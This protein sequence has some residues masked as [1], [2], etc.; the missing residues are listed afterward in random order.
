MRIRAKAFLFS[1]LAALIFSSCNNFFH[2]LIPPSDNEIKSFR[3]MDRNGNDV[4]ESSEIDGTNINIKVRPDADISSLLPLIEKPEKSSVFPIT[5][6][7]IHTAAPSAN[8]INVARNIQESRQAGNLSDWALDFVQKTPDFNVP[9]L[10]QPISFIASVPIAVIA[11]T[12]NTKIYQVN[13]EHGEWTGDDGIEGNCEKQILSFT[14]EGQEGESEITTNEVHFS[15]PGGTDVR[16]ILPSVVVSSGASVLPFTQD[17]ILDLV[18]TSDF[19][20]LLSGYSATNRNGSNTPEKF[21]ASWIRKNN[22]TFPTELT[23]EID[24]SS[25]VD[26]IVRG[27][28]GSV[29]IYKVSC[30]VNSDTPGLTSL[31]FAK[32]TNENLVRDSQTVFNAGTTSSTMDIIYPAEY[33]SDSAGKEDAFHLVPSFVME[34]DKA[35]YSMDGSTWTLLKDSETAIPFTGSKKDCRIKISRG[36]KSTE[37]E[38]NLNYVEDPDTIR[39]VTDFRFPKNKNSGIRATAMASIVDDGNMGTI[40]VTVLYTGTRPTELTPTFVTPGSLYKD[41]DTQTSGV[42]SNC[43]DTPFQYLCISR[44]GM[45]S[46]T[47]TVKVNFVEVQPAVAAMRT[48]TFPQILNPALSSDAVGIINDS[49]ET[50]VVNAVYFNEKPETLVAE[51]SA[52]GNV[53]A[54]GIPQSSGSSKLDFRYARSYTVTASDDPET[55][56]TY[57]VQVVY[58]MDASR[59]CSLDSLCFM[60]EDNPQLSKDVTVDISQTNMTGTALLPV[61]SDKKNTPLIARFEAQGV[62]SINGERQTSGVNAVSFADDVVYTVTSA[63]GSVT[64]EY[65]ISLTETGAIVYVNKNA[66]GLNN[67]TSWED[68]YTTLKAASD[69]VSTN[70]PD[71]T[72]VEVWIADREYDDYFNYTARDSKILTVRGGFDGTEAAESERGAEKISTNA[73]VIVQNKAHLKDLHL[74]NLGSV[75]VIDS[76]IHGE[77]TATKCSGQK[78][79]GCGIYNSS[80]NTVSLTDCELY[81]NKVQ[82]E[83]DFNAEN[84]KGE[85]YDVS[86]KQLNMSNCTCGLYNAKANTAL[87]SDSDLNSGT[88]TEN[89]RNSLTLPTNSNNSVIDNCKIG[90]LD[91]DKSGGYPDPGLCIRDCVIGDIAL[92]NA[93]YVSFYRCKVGTL[94]DT[95]YGIRCKTGK[96]YYTH[97]KSIRNSEI[98]IPDLFYTGA[99]L[100][101]YDSDI[102][103]KLCACGGNTIVA[104]CTFDYNIYIH[105]SYATIT[106]NRLRN[107]GRTYKN[108][109]ICICLHVREEIAFSGNEVIDDFDCPLGNGKERLFSMDLD[110][111]YNAWQNFSGEKFCSLEVCNYDTGNPHFTFSNCQMHHIYEF[112][113]Q[114]EYKNCTISGGDANF[115]DGLMQNCTFI[116]GATVYSGTGTFDSCIPCRQFDLLPGA[117][118]KNMT[119]YGCEEG[120]IYVTIHTGDTDTTRTT[121]IE[122]C[123]FLACNGSGC[124]IWDGNANIRNCVFC[125]NNYQYSGAGLAFVVTEPRWCNVENCLFVNNNSGAGGAKDGYAK[126]PSGSSVN[127]SNTSAAGT[128]FDIWFKFGKEGDISAGLPAPVIEN[129]HAD[130]FL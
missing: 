128:I 8:L 73:P 40:T 79:N 55:K 35:E 26:F 105:S 103:G 50:I 104:G 69:A 10:D 90:G 38:I 34:G 91:I 130:D 117:T 62:V 39:S 14:V 119:F 56:K 94:G 67:G 95:S 77:L 88:L 106:N 78:Q 32:F 22:I 102:S 113:A 107:R 33:I 36:T 57:R 3:L 116:N 80:A 17:Y 15:M 96:Y 60:K 43:Y 1:I 112:K 42:T 118:V 121:T 23:K 51:F 111:Y 85:L 52:T 122:N 37:Y 6:E 28:D 109:P 25:S 61:G 44:N 76:Q 66:A 54:D 81:V 19:I 9:S 129:R 110:T 101:A 7:Y 48:F 2:D 82:T 70:M 21:L 126:G 46:R 71:G 63:D 11:G 4:T 108:R 123:K 68:A 24:F 58:K 99:N 41:G 75:A 59:A 100:E 120:G 124:Q 45:Y 92:A 89:K 30:K 12:G 16:R 97:V 87:I 115:I 20:A 31:A 47:Y 53:T 127:F 86:A 13:V 84:Y 29:A 64:K 5:I 72:A 125:E 18:D 65:T 74:E 98:N 49:A 27:A 83:G 114:S 93:L